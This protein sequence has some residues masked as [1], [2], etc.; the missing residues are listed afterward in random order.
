MQ[1]LNEK[2]SIQVHGGRQKSFIEWLMYSFSPVYLKNH[3]ELS[4]HSAASL[5]MPYNQ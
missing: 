5:A 3:Q 1:K 4:Q 2:Q